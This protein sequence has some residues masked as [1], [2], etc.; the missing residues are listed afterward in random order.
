MQTLRPLSTFSTATRHSL[1]STA[2]LNQQQ[3]RTFLSNPFSATPQ[4]LTATRTLHYPNKLI[5]DIISDVASYHTFLPYCQESVVTKRSQPALDGKTYPEEAK[6]VIG[7]NNDV[8]ETFTSRI[9]CIP[10]RIVEAVSGNAETTLSP[11]E[12]SHHS[13]RPQNA[14]EDSS[15]KTTSISHIL[16]RWT[17]KPYPYKPPPVSA[18]HPSTTHKNH[19]ETSE[20]PSQERTDVTL[21][22][23]YLFANPMY[24]ALSSAAAPKV[25]EKMIE[26][27]ER[28]VRSVIEGPGDVQLSGKGFADVLRNK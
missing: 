15:R 23:D 3:K 27:F 11:D 18:M 21:K 7:F 20:I 14:A 25:A 13:P 26:A 16:T 28:R 24:A 1:L 6:L 19:D 22:I 17:L 5:Y 9:Y 4:H 12:I 2:R 8:S 10:E